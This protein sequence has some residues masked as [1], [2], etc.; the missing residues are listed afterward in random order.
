[1]NDESLPRSS[2]S[3]PSRTIR[4]EQDAYPSCISA[5]DQERQ[6]AHE[7]RLRQHTERVQAE[8]RR[9]RGEA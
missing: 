7:S 9:L 4:Q 3:R 6:E 5:R 1:M 8:L 2:S